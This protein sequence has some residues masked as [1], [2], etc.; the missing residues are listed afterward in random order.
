[1]DDLTT[2]SSEC[3]AE[4]QALAGSRLLGNLRSN[5]V[6]VVPLS[7]KTVRY[8]RLTEPIGRQKPTED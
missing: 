7:A 3:R 2:D 4:P 5:T 1:M 6:L 8:V